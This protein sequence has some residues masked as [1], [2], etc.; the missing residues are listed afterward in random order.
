VRLITGAKVVRVE[1]PRLPTVVYEKEGGES[2][3]EAEAL[4]VAAGRK[5]NIEGL[6]LDKI[7]VAADRRGIA[8]NAFLQTSR[9]HVYAA[10]DVVGPYQF[11]HIAN[12]QAIVA[13]SHA[14]L[15]I[16]KRAGTIVPWC[17]FTDPELAR[18]GLTEARPGKKSA[19]RSG[20]TARVCKARPRPHG[21]GRRRL[22]KFLVSPGR[23]TRGAHPGERAGE[24]LHEAMPPGRSA[25]RC[26]GSTT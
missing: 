16:R 13:T 25:F 15:P 5:P 18:S 17:T 11:S 14:L 3:V 23:H 21:E 26:T 2:R 1:N 8:V 7:G 19:P 12:Y 24:V 9:P 10:G 4:L 20:C 22:A 6:D